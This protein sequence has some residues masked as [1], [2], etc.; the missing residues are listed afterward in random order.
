MLLVFGQV[1][2]V[3]KWAAMYVVYGR[4]S[5]VVTGVLMMTSHS[6]YLWSVVLGMSMTGQLWYMELAGA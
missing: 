2:G 6:D 4:V 1:S 5:L 3:V